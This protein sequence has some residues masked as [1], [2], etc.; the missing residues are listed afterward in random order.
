MIKSIQL[1]QGHTCLALQTMLRC[2]S[3]AAKPK[4]RFPLTFS[5]KTANRCSWPYRRSTFDRAFSTTNKEFDKQP[6]T[7][8]PFYH[9][10]TQQAEPTLLERSNK[11]ILERFL[12]KYSLSRQTNRILIAESFLQAAITQSNDP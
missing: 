8:M 7:K 3:A 9:Q 11:N 12:D 10:Q 5:A 4:I 2:S 6:L 1:S